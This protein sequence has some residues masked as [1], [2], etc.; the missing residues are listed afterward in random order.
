MTAGTL[1]CPAQHNFYAALCCAV[2]QLHLATLFGHL[3][4]AH[5]LQEA[6]CCFGEAGSEGVQAAPAS[7]LCVHQ[8][9]GLSGPA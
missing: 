6:A 1:C 9:D 2:Q 3:S 4:V 8:L 7:Q 5:A